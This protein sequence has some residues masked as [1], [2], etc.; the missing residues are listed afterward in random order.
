MSEHLTPAAPT[1]EAPGEPLPEGAPDAVPPGEDAAAEAEAE[2]DPVAVMREALLARLSDKMSRSA[3]FPAVRESIRTIQSVAR[4]ETAHLRVFTDQIL[5]DVSVTNKLLRL[6]NTAFYSTVG[7]GTITTVSRAIALMGFSPVGML[8]GSVMLFDKLP[9][10]PHAERMREE[11]AHSLMAAILAHE[12]CPMRQTE[13]NAYISALFQ[14]LGKMLANLHLQEEALQIETQAEEQGLAATDRDGHARLQKEV[15]GLTYDELT[16]EIAQQWGWPESL[17]QSLRPM[18]PEDPEKP[19][20]PHEYLRMVVTG[21]NALGRE[22]LRLPGAERLAAAERFHAQWGIPLGLK[23]EDMEGLVE[24]AMQKWFDV[25]KTLGLPRPGTKPAAKKTAAPATPTTPTKLSG[26]MTPA[27]K[28]AAKTAAPARPAGKPAAA[29]PAVTD[30][31]SRGIEAISQAA[32]GDVPLTQVLQQVLQLLAATLQLQRAI[33]CLRDPGGGPLVG[34]LGHDA[35]AMATAT[36]FRIPLDPP[37][38]LFGLLCAK[39]A[40]TLISD[41]ADPVIAQRLPGW[42]KVQVGAPTF[43]LL[44]LTVQGRCAGL[45]YGDRPAAHSLAVDEATFALLKTLRNQLVMMMRL[46]AAG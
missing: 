29:S 28:P 35:A 23:L 18:V 25:A 14:H 5:T 21:A 19:A 3:D 15:M 45:I 2:A 13:E 46:R 6:I 42:Y 9:K 44:P 37:S 7:G 34:V 33:V 38:D 22:L 41:A 10:G 39:N 30:A 43:L 36:K 32:M 31:L 27:A 11:F 8:A 1:A 16:I 26:P 17:V 12:M 20:E 40:D 4:S 24:R